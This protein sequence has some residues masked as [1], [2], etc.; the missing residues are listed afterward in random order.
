MVP[1]SASCSSRYRIIFSTCVITI[2]CYVVFRIVIDSIYIKSISRGDQY[3]KTQMF[4]YETTFLATVPLEVVR[5][6]MIDINDKILSFEKVLNLFSDPSSGFHDFFNGILRRHFEGGKAYFMEWPAI[7]L[8]T[9]GRNFEFVLIPAIAIQNATA[10]S[11]PFR[12]HFLDARLNETV[13]SFLNIGGDASLVVPC[14]IHEKAAIKNSFTPPLKTSSYN[15]SLLRSIPS[16]GNISSYAHLASFIMNSPYSQ[17]NFLWQK[18]ATVTKEKLMALGGHEKVWISTSG[19][20]VAWL[21][22]RLDT[23]PKYYNW[24]PY[25]MD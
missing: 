14:P 13:I 15:I 17:A 25:Q 3:R 10:N 23:V 18:V 8:P 4:Q 11:N 6:R 9:V 20:G 7:S 19:L 1:T 16:L 12:E 2:F 22:V 24:E 5:F 21:H